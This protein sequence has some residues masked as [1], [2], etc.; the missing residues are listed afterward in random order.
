MALIFII[1]GALGIYAEFSSPGRIAPGVIG[2]ALVVLG[3]ASLARDP[4]DWRG[5][6]LIVIAFGFFLL[7]AR[8]AAHGAFTV[9]GSVC[10]LIGSLLLIDSPD[11][12]RRIHPAT[13]LAATLPFALVT[14]FLLTVALRARRN[15]L[16]VTM[17]EVDKRERQT[18]T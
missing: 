18:Q 17:G 12:R 2:T 15:K 5:A 10:L 7:E 1:A 3:L 14:S 8:A 4:I 16:A 13:A 9:A 11:P 6:A